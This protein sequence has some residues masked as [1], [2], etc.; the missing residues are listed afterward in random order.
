MMVKRQRGK[1][2]ASCLGIGLL[3]GG[4]AGCGG[5]D[6]SEKVDAGQRRYCDARCFDTGIDLGSSVDSGARLDAAVV[7]SSAEAGLADS[8]RIVVDGPLVGLDGAADYPDAPFLQPDSPTDTPTDGPSTSASDATDSRG[9]SDA[10]LDLPA[11]KADSPADRPADLNA[12]QPGDSVEAPEVSPDGPNDL[13]A[14]DDTRD[15]P[16][17]APDG[18]PADLP[19]GGNCLLNAAPWAKDWPKTVTVAAGGSAMGPDGTLWTAGTFYANVDFGAGP[20]TF[21]ESYP[22]GG[23]PKGDA[24]LAKLD[25]QTGSASASIAFGDV[26]NSMQKVFQVAVAKNGNIALQ[27][28]VQGEI[29]FSDKTSDTGDPGTDYLVATN[30]TQF[31]AVLP[32]TAAGPHVAAI[33]AHLLDI[34]YGT[35]GATLISLVSHPDQ[36][37]FY[38]CGH[39]GKAVPAWADT[40]TNKG[41]ITGSAGTFG[42]GLD[43]VVAKIDAESG[44]VLWGKQFGG[45]GDQK[46]LGL[47]VDGN[48]DVFVAGTN[49]GTLDFGGPTTATS[50]SASGELVVAKLSGTDGAALL[51]KTWGTGSGP[52]S[53]YQTLTL[54]VDGS[55][56]VFL[57][58]STKS[59]IDFGGGLTLVPS[60]T[61]SFRAFIAKLTTDLVPLWG[62]IYGADI[63]I[64][65]DAGVRTSPANQYVNALAATSTGGVL[66]AGQYVG[67]LGDL[68]VPQNPNTGGLADGFIAQLSSDGA[69]VCA[70]A[71]SNPDHLGNHQVTSLAVARAA[72]GD[73]KDMVS[74]GG[75]FTSSIQIGS[76]TLTTEDDATSH[77]FIGRLGPQP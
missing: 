32:A 74:A 35:N 18:P 65:D 67:G 9:G 3:I 25:P 61:A 33:K 51:A 37:A 62:H 47:A 34:G 46:C 49:K 54:V 60:N 58:G 36:N 75:T 26:N 70:K 69:K 50:G 21:S 10:V 27:G 53:G 14:G 6:S 17:E 71:Y 44:A 59:T 66:I 39:A 8:P 16:T 5:G 55:N 48:G 42:G 24:F 23:S 73:L 15:A 40:G 13:I 38:L 4:A 76:K 30:S 2:L 20:L 1:V 64:T 22:S 43:I 31:Y 45:D 7:D 57:G 41:L 68:G 11:D 56:N 19:A 52:A 72:T 77:A 12:D 28:A 29:D 63:E